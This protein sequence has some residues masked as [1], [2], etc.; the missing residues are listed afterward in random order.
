[1]HQRV[2]LRAEASPVCVE[3]HHPA[4]MDRAARIQRPGQRYNERNQYAET[5]AWIY[6]H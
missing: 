6:T 1:M 3:Q 4:P 5:T 2:L